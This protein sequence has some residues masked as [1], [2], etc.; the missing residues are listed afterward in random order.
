MDKEIKKKSNKLVWKIAA[1]ILLLA[2]TGYTVVSAMDKATMTIE[3]D[4]VLFTEVRNDQFYEYISITGNIEPANSYLVDSK[5]S[6]TVQRVMAESGDELLEGDTLLQLVN[7]DLRLEVMQRESQLIEQLNNQAQTKILLNQNN[8][9]QREQ[10]I[11]INYQIELQT[12]LYERNKP[13]FEQGVISESTFEPIASRYEYLQKRRTLIQQ[14]YQTD[15]I[16]RSIQLRQ[17]DDSEVRIADN[18]DAVQ[19]ILN[20]LYIITPVGGQLSDFEIQVGEAVE[21]G[22]RLGQVFSLK[23]PKI[24]AEVDEFYLNKVAVGQPGITVI[25]NDTIDLVVEKVFP[26]VE[27][28]AFQIEIG[29]R[30]PD[31]TGQQFIKGQTLRISLFFGQPS[32]TV[33]LA[34]GNF[35]NS[36]GGNWVYVVNGDQA[37]KKNI[38]LGR[39]NPKHF[40]VLEGLK[41][42]E[43]V[44]ISSYDNYKNYETIKLN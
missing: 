25:N 26:S 8:L 11:E 10:V 19:Q 9:S 15:S 12:Q 28:G 22:Q 18:L 30:A 16:A 7:A 29:L 33:L 36:T 38:K 4:R 37:E 43:K 41:P 44:I 20:R 21:S 17:I 1:A 35:Y 34:S 3:K 40:E 6:G 5:I 13:L 24:T 39:R 32:E 31:S 27:E 23:R 14:T 42:G 2:L